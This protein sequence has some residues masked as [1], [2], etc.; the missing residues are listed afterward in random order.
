MEQ[1]GTDQDLIGV[2]SVDTALTDAESEGS[3]IRHHVVE[4][5]GIQFPG[6]DTYFLDR[7]Q[8]G[9]SVSVCP[10]TFDARYEMLTLDKA[11][12]CLSWG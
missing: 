6:T 12:N 3:P 4:P 5:D 1:T 8:L 7:S 2:P 11:R 9:L 10:P